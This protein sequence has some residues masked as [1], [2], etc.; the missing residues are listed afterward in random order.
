MIGNK[1]KYNTIQ[2]WLSTLGQ[3]LFIIFIADIDDVILSKKF[4]FQVKQSFVKQWV[5]E[6]IVG[7]LQNDQRRMFN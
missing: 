6:G 5:N 2:S 3:L 7:I 1:R 4:K